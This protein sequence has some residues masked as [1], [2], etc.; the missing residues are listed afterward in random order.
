MSKQRFLSSSFKYKEQDPSFMGDDLKEEYQDGPV[1]TRKCT[2]LFCCLLFL[3][4]LAA[5]VYLGVLGFSTGDPL[6]LASPFDEDGKQCGRDPGYQEYPKIF[7]SFMNDDP[8]DVGFIC[9]RFCPT[10]PESVL[11]C[12]PNSKVPGC[13]SLKVYSAETVVNLCYPSKEILV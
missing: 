10:D 11:D 6:L 5:M 2:D 3:A 7:I 4:L 13:D 12:V 1:P 9:V 8:T